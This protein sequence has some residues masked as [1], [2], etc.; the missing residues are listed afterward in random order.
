MSSFRTEYDRLHDTLVRA[1]PRLRGRPSSPAA[2]ALEVAAWALTA[3]EQHG[4]HAVVRRLLTG[5]AETTW[6]LQSTP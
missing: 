3:S 5:V 4:N 1:E 6:R 2:M